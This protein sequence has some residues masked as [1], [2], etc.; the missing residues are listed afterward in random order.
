MIDIEYLHERCLE[1]GD[2]WIWQLACSSNG[3]PKFTH[4]RK[5]LAVR[6]VM[7]ELIGKNV[8]GKLATNTCGNPRCVNPDHIKVTGK[9]EMMKMVVKRTGYPQQIARRKKISDSK[10]QI[11]KITLEQAM[12][13]RNSDETIEQAAERAGIS[14]G[15][16]WRI[17]VGKTWKDYGNPWGALIG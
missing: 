13:V 2:C 4:E 11:A 6:R 10:R 14:K 16:A 1:D 8:E 7:A 15:V 12:E 5:Q 17:R 3:T 9:S